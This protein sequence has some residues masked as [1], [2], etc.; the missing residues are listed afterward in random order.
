MNLMNTAIR[1]TILPIFF[2]CFLVSSLRSQTWQLGLLGGG[3]NYQG[4]LQDKY[5]NLDGISAAV[6]VSAFYSPQ[7][8]FN[9]SAEIMRGTLTGSDAVPGA[10]NAA[11]NLQFVTRFYELSFQGRFNFIVND[12][13]L[14]IPYASAG[15]SGFHINPFTPAEGGRIYLFPLGTE[16][17][18]LREHPDR[19]MNRHINAALLAG[20]GLEVR[21]SDNLKLDMEVV[22]RK[23]F[24]DYI[25]DVSTT[26]PDA[27]ALLRER[28]P[29]AL[30]YAYRGS[31][32]E[33]PV[34]TTRGNPDT[35]DMYH[36]VALRLR[37]TLSSNYLN[38]VYGK[39]LFRKRGWPYTR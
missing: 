39:S 13:A 4:E 36:V 27:Q 28:G 5:I 8:R 23:T 32:N 29:L 22:F 31:A 9:F 38:P 37:Y 12:E 14:I 15:L 20:G 30:R 33:M 19:K 1:L 17:Q 26:Y 3:A 10:R 35:K 16:G 18:G 6:G 7:P 2:C 34:G 21:L 24:T 11:R 25:D